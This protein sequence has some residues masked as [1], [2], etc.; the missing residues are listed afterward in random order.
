MIKQ[1]PSNA[2]IALMVAFT[3]SCIA[4]L[5]Y[6]WVSFGGSIPLAAKG[7]RV[8]VNFPE[9][10]SLAQNADVRISGVPVGHVVSTKL[11]PGNTTTTT[12]ELRS[13]Y[14]PLPRDARAVLRQKT[15]LGETYV[16]L[17]PGT[18]RPGNYV[19]DGGTLA[20]SQ[21]SPTV[22]LDEIFRAFDPKTRAAFET[23]MQAQAGAGI[24]RGPDLNAALGNLPDFTDKTTRLLVDLNAQSGAV[25]RLVSN[26][27]VVFDAISQRRGALR[28]LISAS[29]EVF[30]VTAQRNRELAAAF[31]AL[32]TF[33]QESSATLERL[34]KFADDTNPLIT[35]LQP[36]AQEFSPTMQQVL[37]L[38]PDLHALFARLNP[39][40]DAS[41][42]GLPAL[43]RLLDDLK[44]LLGQVDPFLRNAN[45][46]FEFLGLY[47][48]ELTAF[49]A[50]V[51]ASTE[52]KTPPTKG[53]PAL[54]YL[55]TENP[56]T[57]L[58]LAF[59]PHIP[60]FARQNAYAQPGSFDQLATGLPVFDATNCSNPNPA[61]P[62]STIP[63]GLQE[64]I[65][66]LVF[67]SST[68]EG[69]PTPPC[70]QQGRFAGG[71][72]FP[73]LRASP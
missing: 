39:L 4:A 65:R 30:R 15:L 14:A 53:N 70:R 24:G 37:A 36:V 28:N 34:T 56:L 52:A 19:A 47:K 3:L 23:W 25:R 40:I 42:D 45:P 6:L 50:N 51:V 18:R 44:P 38:A 61:P 55:R 12:I 8:K 20:Q 72:Q 26:T 73:Q 43:Q 58:G 31:V 17:A 54:Q 29:N 10:V 41:R 63:D 21:V 67:R 9:A 46:L 33:E 71:T 59:Y 69:I 64:L 11:G 57:P 7:Y 27:G 68:R 22:Q 48:R 13:R 66:D 16:E 32:P 2:R 1:R 35:Q 60:G 62:T 5:L 49:F